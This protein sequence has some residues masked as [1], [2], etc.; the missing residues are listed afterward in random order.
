MSWQDEPKI[1]T[2]LDLSCRRVRD[3]AIHDV[4]LQFV[5]DHTAANGDECKRLCRK[6]NEAMSGI[7]PTRE[8][9]LEVMA[10]AIPDADRAPRYAEIALEALLAELPVCE[11]HYD[12]AYCYEKLEGMRKP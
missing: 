2:R 11:D 12:A 6:G 10:A 5:L 7:M 1:E 8:R 3:R 4:L 9:L